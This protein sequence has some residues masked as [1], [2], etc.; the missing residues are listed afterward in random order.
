MIKTTAHSC[1]ERGTPVSKMKKIVATILAVIT[2]M[3]ATITAASAGGISDFF[4]GIGKTVAHIGKAAYH[5]AVG[6]VEAVTTSKSTS[7]C[8]HEL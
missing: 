4:S 5:V 7:E 2:L 8:Y 6:T 1:R 3:T